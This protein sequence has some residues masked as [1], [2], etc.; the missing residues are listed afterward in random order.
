MYQLL[1]IS[2]AVNLM[3]N[4][5]LESLLGNARIKNHQLNITGMLV[6]LDGSF[7][8][9]LEGEKAVVK[10]SF[11][12]ISKDPRHNNI[13]LVDENHID[14]RAFQSWEMAFHKLHANDIEKFPAIKNLLNKSTQNQTTMLTDIVDSFLHLVVL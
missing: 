5:E 1:Y 6:Y 8:Q 3:S 13:I 12:N 9:V 10:D 14:K 4:D 11:K 2:N 7:I